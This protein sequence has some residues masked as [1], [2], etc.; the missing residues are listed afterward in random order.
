V[1]AL[2][3]CSVKRS[4]YLNTFEFLDKIKEFLD[5]KLQPSS[6]L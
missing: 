2:V 3:S 4:D 1:R 5:R 6:C